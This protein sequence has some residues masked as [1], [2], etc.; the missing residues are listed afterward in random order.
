VVQR[1]VYRAGH[2]VGRYRFAECARVAPDGQPLGD[3][4]PYPEILFPFDR[5][6]R[7]AGTDLA[8][9]PVRAMGPGPLVEERYEV[10]PL[11]VVSIT[12]TDLDTGFA[13]AFQLGA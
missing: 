13:K 7:A 6:L 9:V 10:T 8:S 1:R 4:T 2:N 12:L 5:S 3:L 11:G